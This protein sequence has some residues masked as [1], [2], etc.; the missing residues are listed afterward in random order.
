[1]TFNDI[2][3]LAL[4]AISLSGA[5]TA[6]ARALVAKPT[7]I[8]ECCRACGAKTPIIGDEVC[9]ECWPE[10][11]WEIHCAIDP[12]ILLQYEAEVTL[13]RLLGMNR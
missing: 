4:V 9:Q 5:V 12:W 2:M 13:M 6:F 8:I 10:I 7:P 3:T 1:M 11:Q